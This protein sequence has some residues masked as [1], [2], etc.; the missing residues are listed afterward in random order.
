MAGVSG[1]TAGD[2]LGF[3]PRPVVCLILKISAFDLEKQEHKR[4]SVKR[5]K[6][7]YTRIRKCE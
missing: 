2:F 3:L 7:N 6:N 4:I 5:L 1:A